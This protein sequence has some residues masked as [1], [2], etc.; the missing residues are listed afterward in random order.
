MA[1][2]V[3]NCNSS[4]AANMVASFTLVDAEK[5]RPTTVTRSNSTVALV[6]HC[7]RGWDSLCFHGDRQSGRG[8]LTS[9]LGMSTPTYGDSRNHVE[10]PI[11]PFVPE[12]HN[13]P[14]TPGG[15]VLPSGR[16]ERALAAR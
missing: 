16:A 14:T 10:L 11:E 2:L 13:S 9:G 15:L 6:R 1:F 8:R 3:A 5:R 12:L 4:A 7:S